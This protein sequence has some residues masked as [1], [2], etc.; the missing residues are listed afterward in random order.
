MTIKIWAPKVINFVPLWN[1]GAKVIN[2]VLATAN[3][4]NPKHRRRGMD[5]TTDATRSKALPAGATGYDPCTNLPVFADAL[6]LAMNGEDEEDTETNR[7]VHKRKRSKR[8]KQPADSP[9]VDWDR[10]TDDAESEEDSDHCPYVDTE[11][12]E[13]DKPEESPEASRTTFIQPLLA[14]PRPPVP[15]PKLIKPSLQVHAA[16]AIDG[17]PMLQIASNI[18]AVCKKSAPVLVNPTVND[19]QQK[20][21]SEEDKKSVL[22]YLMLKAVTEK[23]WDP[24]KAKKETDKKKTWK[25]DLKTGKKVSWYATNK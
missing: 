24:V 2:F 10:L 20:E 18:A 21:D 7:P 14:R 22:N 1:L 4:V 5:A 9:V 23:I 6:Y 13:D 19:A 16:K 15:V 12:H 3:P 25:W 11:A 8:R 17:G